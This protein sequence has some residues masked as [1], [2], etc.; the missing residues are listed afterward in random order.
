MKRLYVVFLLYWLLLNLFKTLTFKLRGI[1]L[2][3]LIIDQC[4]L[5][6]PQIE[7]K[8]ALPD[9]LNNQALTQNQGG[10]NYRARMRRCL[11][12][13]PF[14]RIKTKNLVLCRYL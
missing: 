11:L 8:I 6:Y 12:Y 7:I 14:S 10:Y 4:N 3:K 2:S 9:W 13:E 1:N 5:T